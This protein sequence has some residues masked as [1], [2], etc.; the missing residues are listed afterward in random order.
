MFIHAGRAILSCLHW[1]VEVHSSESIEIYFRHPWFDSQLQPVRI[2]HDWSRHGR[3]RETVSVRFPPI[4]YWSRPCPPTRSQRWMWFL[5][6]LISSASS[7]APVIAIFLSS[8]PSLHRIHLGHGRLLTAFAD[9]TMATTPF[10]ELTLPMDMRSPI[11]SIVYQ[12][13]YAWYEWWI[14]RKLTGCFQFSDSA[15]YVI[16]VTHQYGYVAIKLTR[17]NERF[18]FQCWTSDCSIRKLSPEE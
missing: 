16:I 18:C 2:L 9:S 12:S 3:I 5:T 1:P 17:C 11:R 4:H 6:M 7:L 8:V 10:E 13:M 15:S 14:S